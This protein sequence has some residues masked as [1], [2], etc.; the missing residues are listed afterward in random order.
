MYQFQWKK[1]QIL[2]QRIP[3][4]EGQF[5]I[6]ILALVNELSLRVKKRNTNCVGKTSPF[7]S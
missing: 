3:P 1:D 6:L 4:N 2:L 7:L 5:P